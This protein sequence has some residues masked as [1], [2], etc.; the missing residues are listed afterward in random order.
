MRTSIYDGFQEPPIVVD[1][2]K[3]IINVD[4]IIAETEGVKPKVNDPRLLAEIK[5]ELTP[6]E[7]EAQA[8]ALEVA[9][10]KFLEEDK[11]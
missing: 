4:K 8:K 11:K 1:K 5:D 3:A 6:A 9:A 7:I 2:D 10:K